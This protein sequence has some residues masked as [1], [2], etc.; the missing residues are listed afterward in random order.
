[1]LMD[2]KTELGQLGGQNFRLGFI[3]DQGTKQK[4]EGF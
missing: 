3:H 4:K 2:F 1:M